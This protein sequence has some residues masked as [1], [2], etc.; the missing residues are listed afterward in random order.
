MRVPL[1]LLVIFLCTNLVSVILYYWKY[2]LIYSNGDF[3][4][5]LKQKI[6][7]NITSEYRYDLEREYNSVLGKDNRGL[8]LLLLLS[9]IIFAII[10][11]LLQICKTCWKIGRLVISLLLITICLFFAYFSL[12]NSFKVKNKVNLTDEEIYVFD[13]EFN[14]E[15]KEQLN[16]MY[17]RKNYLIIC[18]IIFTVGLFA[19]YIIILIDIEIW[20]S[21]E[22]KNENNNT[23]GQDVVV[24][25]ET[26]RQRNN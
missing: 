8:E 1:L 19:Q 9:G 11:V 26:D 5:T 6:E 4:N 17:E 13:E 20:Y 7:S 15:L 24:Y 16:I 21:N 12:D 25:Q 10:A 18:G 23:L 2:D 14:N 22:E 3:K